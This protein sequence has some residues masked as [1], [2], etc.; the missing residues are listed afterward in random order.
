MAFFKIISNLASDKE[1]GISRTYTF[2]VGS[3]VGFPLAER[4]NDGVRNF[5]KV[6]QVLYKKK[7]M[8][9][10]TEK[11]KIEEHNILISFMNKCSKILKNQI[12]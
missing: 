3:K 9:K 4:K 2:S 5:V 10:Y 12:A 8:N 1:R 6:I 7:M 11:I